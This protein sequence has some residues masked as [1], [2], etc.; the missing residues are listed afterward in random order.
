MTKRSA[1]SSDLERAR[2]LARRLRPEGL[3][4]SQHAEVAPPEAPGYVRFVSAA[5]P[6]PAAFHDRL[7]R[8]LETTRAQAI[9]VFGLDGR[10]LGVAGQWTAT[11]SARLESV[12]ARL[13]VALGQAE[14]IEGRW[15]GPRSVA[16]AIGAAW[17]AGLRLTT[18]AG[19]LTVGLLSDR[20]LEHQALAQVLQELQPPGTGPWQEP[21]PGARGDGSSV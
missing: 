4:P 21:G 10:A 6:E 17:V 14:R 13:A 3:L 20:P 18:P 2:A 5:S 8:C 11:P 19:R 12:G 15:D 7:T 1:S 16:L 9:A